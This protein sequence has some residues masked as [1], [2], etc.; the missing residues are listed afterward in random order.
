MA[1]ST[2]RA[3]AGA[4][5]PL[6]LSPLSA[7]SRRPSLAEA[8]ARGAAVAALR[9]R[10]SGAG[11]RSADALT[12]GHRAP[13]VFPAQLARRS[14]RW[15]TAVSAGCRLLPLRS[16]AIERSD[17]IHELTGPRPDDAGHAGGLL[18]GKLRVVDAG[19]WIVVVMGPM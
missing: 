7:G 10:S 3:Q 1:R 9:T 2:T 4:R 19:G 5:R 6:L 18:I 14:D 17:R 13:F 11:T 8:L 15:R 12:L 16:C